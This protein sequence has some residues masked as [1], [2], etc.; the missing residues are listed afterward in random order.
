MI[1]VLFYVIGLGSLYWC[2]GDIM[3]E[4]TDFKMKK[5]ILKDWRDSGMI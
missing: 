2:V 3:D 4:Y 5:S 1:D